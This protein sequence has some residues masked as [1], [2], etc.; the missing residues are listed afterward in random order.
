MPGID[1]YINLLNLFTQEKS[2]WT[3]SEVSAKLNVPASTVYRTMRDLKRVNMLDSAGEARYRLGPAFIE[4]DR[5]TR[6]T[7]PLTQQSSG[8]MS[9]LVHHAAVPCMALIS[10]LYGNTVMCVASAASEGSWPQSSYERGRPMPLTH[11][12]TSKAILAQL[13]IRRLRMVVDAAS[14]DTSTVAF[15]TLRRELARI[16]K[17]GYAVGHG[18]VDAD[19]VGIAV[20]LSI[21]QDGIIGSLSLVL[22][23]EDWNEENGRRLV[24]LLV[25]SAALLQQQLTPG[26]PQKA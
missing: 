17:G 8:M 12:A 11:G 20:P 6:L 19:R 18:E 23:A 16:R 1:R 22:Y 9:E 10:R 24:L 3:V 21:I 7:D 26:G 25:S 13:T 15:E 4:L 2:S 14:P 5:R